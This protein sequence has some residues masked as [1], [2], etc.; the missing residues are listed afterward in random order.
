M[1]PQELLACTLLDYLLAFLFG[2]YASCEVGKVSCQEESSRDEGRERRKRVPPIP[3]PRLVHV[4]VACRVKW[5]F[6]V[7]FPRPFQYFSE[8][9]FP[10]R[11]CMKPV[12]TRVR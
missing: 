6:C 9:R 7:K 5:K 8:W 3:V 2:F 1:F 11:V 10:L 12:K 4:L